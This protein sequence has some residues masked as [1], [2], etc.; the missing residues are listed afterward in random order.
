MH[1]L[2]RSSALAMLVAAGATAAA[3]PST[4]TSQDITVTLHVIDE[5]RV[6]APRLGAEDLAMRIFRT[7]ACAC[8][9][10]TTDR[11]SAGNARA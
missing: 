8:S 7:P 4:S 11:A 1:R 2:F 9:G 5:A 10:R 6:A 3:K